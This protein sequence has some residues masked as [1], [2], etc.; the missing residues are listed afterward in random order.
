MLAATQQL[1]EN[2]RLWLWLAVSL[3]LHSLIFY[4]FS[5]EWQPPSRLAP[6]PETIKVD[7]RWSEP[8]PAAEAAAKPAAPSIFEPIPLQRPE[9]ALPK[10]DTPKPAP[11]PEPAAPEA[12]PEAEAAPEP[13][14]AKPPPV[15]AS[16]EEPT[17]K[18]S[19]AEQALMRRHV[20]LMT[21]RIQAAWRPPPNA[22]RSMKTELSLRILPDGAVV[23]VRVRVG[24]GDQAFDLS[25]VA[26]ARAAA[27]FKHLTEL[28]REL[29]DD[30]F[31]RLRF[32]FQPLDLKP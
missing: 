21:E 7:L 15:S 24:S 22:K 6:V 25:A 26:A 29:F 16:S 8:P 14:V 11:P 9:L 12:P 5:R 32:R 1:P 13:E 30:Y 2:Q 20:Q 28:P 17:V 10:P 31:R 4:A 18:L 27:P 23:A 19:P 3:S